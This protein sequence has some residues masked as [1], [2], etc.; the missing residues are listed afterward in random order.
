MDPHFAND[1][2]IKH[3]SGAKRDI[4]AWIYHDVKNMISLCKERGV[5]IIVQN[6][7]SPQKANK[8]LGRVARDAEISFLDQFHL[9]SS[10]DSSP[11]PLFI[12]DGHCSDAGYRRMAEHL[13]SFLEK[14][15]DALG[16]K[17]LTNE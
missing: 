5:P 17:I 15:F 4:A 9:F 8:V 7:P 1:Y 11:E 13:F 2:R 10:Y 16:K 12:A 6:Y 14:R 3:D